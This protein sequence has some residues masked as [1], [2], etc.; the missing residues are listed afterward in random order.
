MPNII[1]TRLHASAS[2]SA[3]AMAGPTSALR[4]YQ[5]KVV[6]RAVELYGKGTRRLLVPLATGLGKTVIF[7]HLPQV[8]TL[9]PDSKTRVCALVY[10]Q[11]LH[12][13][14]HL[15]VSIVLA[16]ALSSWQRKGDCDAADDCTFST[17]ARA[18]PINA[19]TP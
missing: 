17:A 6:G 16:G 1:T 3:T 4:P 15:F 11:L 8:H 7:T 18:M 13:G 10:T 19:S 5:A 9:E 2:T 12:V 14:T